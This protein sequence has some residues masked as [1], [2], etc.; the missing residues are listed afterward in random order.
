MV[1]ITFITLLFV[2][3]HSLMT[4]FTTISCCHVQKYHSI[5]CDPPYLTCTHTRFLQKYSYFELESLFFL[6]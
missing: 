2:V 1:N 3:A 5:N 6:K 4:E